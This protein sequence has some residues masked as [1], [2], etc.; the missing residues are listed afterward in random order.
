MIKSVESK[1]R[2]QHSKEKINPVAK[3]N[4]KKLVRSPSEV[5]IDQESHFTEAPSINRM[6]TIQLKSPQDLKEINSIKE[7]LDESGFKTIQHDHKYSDYKSIDLKES[8][9]NNISRNHR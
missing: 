2:S 7:S 4:Q 8:Q 1:Q 3:L 9:D 6:E 5:I